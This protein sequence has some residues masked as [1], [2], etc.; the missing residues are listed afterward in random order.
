MEAHSLAV[1]LRKR[2]LHGE[3]VFDLAWALLLERLGHLAADAGCMF[4]LIHDEG[5]DKRLRTLTREARRLGLAHTGCRVGGSARLPILDDPVPRSSKEA[6][7]V[8]LADL[9]AWA[10][11]RRVDGASGDSSHPAVPAATWERLGMSRISGG[12]RADSRYPGII[13]WA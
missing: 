11:V 1:V 2:D 7:F 5:K 4:K 10:A 8:Q 12:L 13:T 6:W 3:D 9:V